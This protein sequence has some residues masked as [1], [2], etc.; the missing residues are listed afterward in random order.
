M[1]GTFSQ[2]FSLQAA[3]GLA[4]IVCA[5]CAWPQTVR[6]QNAPVQQTLPSAQVA[7]Q[8]PAWCKGLPRPAYK[9]LNNVPVASDW[10]EV[11]KIRPGVFAI[12]E[13]LQEEEV[14]SYLILGQKRAL[15]FDT[16]LGVGNIRAIV[17]GLTQL[18]VTVLNSHTHFDHIG[19]NADFDDVVAMD[20][21]YTRRNA[22]GDPKGADKVFWPGALCGRLPAGVDPATWVLRG[23]KIS[24]YVHDGDRIDLGGRT[25]RVI[26]TPGH[27]PDAIC[28]FDEANGLLFTGDTFYLGPIYLFV[29]ETSLPD[30]FASVDRLAAME[31]KVKLLLP[32]H[33]IPVA[34]P[35]NLTAL[36]QAVKALQAGGVKPQQ[37]NMGWDYGFEGFSFLLATPYKQ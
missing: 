27:T 21:D 15:L 24:S 13:P 8:A 17:Q 35:D 16:G 5:W 14:I 19:G 29:P 11:Y 20:T 4:G 1:S 37:T 9:S 12:Y 34:N 31:P 33:N 23:F 36:K 25:L 26:A 3:M 7:A 18:P 10:F 28:L 6:A 2:R 22:M 32:A 30:Y